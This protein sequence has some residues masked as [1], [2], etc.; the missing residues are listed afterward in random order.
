MFRSKSQAFTLIELLVVIA[1]I[2]ILAAILFPVFA[3]AREQARK[4]ACLSNMKQWGLAELMYQQD[5]DENFVLWEAVEPLYR[6]NGTLYRPYSPWTV[7]IQPYIKNKALG[8]CPDQT[9]GG[10]GLL[11]TVNSHSLLYSGYGYNYGYLN[12]W[13]VVNGT[14]PPDPNPACGYCYETTPLADAGVNRPA[15]EVMFLDY[16]GLDIDAAS[17]G[18]VYVPINDI[19]DA[20]DATYSSQYFWGSGWGGSCNDYTTGYDYPCYGGADFR[21]SGG[22]YQQG[23]TP[24][25]GANVCFTDGHAKYYRVGGLTAGTTY[26]PTQPSSSTY[27]INQQAYLWNPNY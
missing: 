8:L 27:V 3:Q 6:D 10:Q 12:T 11:D 21:H 7:L 20:P 4:T 18:S 1:I 5:Y 15:Q 13:V 16:Q 9:N 14:F 23:V 22:H 19:V 24:S 26:S 2:A 17:P 25:G